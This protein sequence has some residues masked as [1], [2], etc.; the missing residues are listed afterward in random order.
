LSKSVRKSSAAL[1]LAAGLA[2][3]P[4][5][6]DTVAVPTDGDAYVEASIGDASYL[7]PVLAY[8]SASNDINALVYNGL[9]KY[10]K[11]IRL[12]GELA[13]SWEI[14]QGGKEF[15]FHLRPNV[16]WHDG[17]PFTAEDVKFTYERLIDPKVKT[18]FGSDYQI[19]D[20]VEA[21]DPLTFRVIYK[22][23]YAPALESWGMGI[24][25]KHIFENGDFNQNPANR[26]PIG[27]GPYK[28]VEWKT[29]EKI[30]LTVNPDYFEGRPRLN[31]YIYRIIPD[32]AV[33]FLELR[34]QSIDSM[35]LTPD[36]YKAYPEFFIHYN[37]YRYPSFSYT[38]L[39]F[40]LRR[41]MFAD[42]RVRQALAHAVNKSE[43]ID[44]VLLGI[45]RPATG[46][47]PPSSWAYNPAVKDYDFNPEKAK[48]M[49]AEAGWKDTNGDGWLDKDGQ[50]FEFTIITNQGNKTREL[51]SLIIQNHLQAVGIKVHV[52]IIEWA[53]FLHN[54]INK[55][56]FDAA[57]LGWNLSRDPDQYV[58]WHSGQTGDNQYNHVGYNN[59]EVDKILEDGRREFNFEKRKALYNR[60]HALLADDLP[61]IFLYYPDSLPVIHKR[62]QGP[63]VAPAGL[64]WNFR[65]WFVPKGLQRYHYGS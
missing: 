17:A 16:R 42:K 41:P 25:P 44:G 45:G 19:V 51:S 47:F 30:V 40:N 27:T 11:D 7:N 13:Q 22:E 32:N 49:L 52:R 59:P 43:I 50:R 39:S 64:G 33:Q 6:A 34:Q 55:R 58:I 57:L 65:E 8:D 5:R 12:V 53:S 18:P 24:L 56:N 2:A 10:D 9:M 36:Q 63:Q 1:A 23:P 21:P 4:A 35:G 62:I 26:R 61:Y 29:D 28:F 60:M 3:G 46:P 15:I 37:K 54:F 20:R 14:K 38:Y 48:A 31:R